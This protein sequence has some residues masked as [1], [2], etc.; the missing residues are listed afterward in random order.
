[1]KEYTLDV[2]SWHFRLAN[3]GRTRISPYQIRRG[4]D[5]CTYTRAVAQGAF[6]ALTMW[7]SISAVVAWIGY[8]IYDLVALLT[9]TGHD[10]FGTTIIFLAFLTALAILL[11]FGLVLEGTKYAKEKLRERRYANLHSGQKEPQPGF[12]ALTYRKLKD[13][14]CF[15]INF[16]EQ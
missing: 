6:R 15:K 16:E 14:T 9:T 10:L 12:F 5:F 4:T 11:V 1:M 8:A 2:N 7:V 13:K 3:S